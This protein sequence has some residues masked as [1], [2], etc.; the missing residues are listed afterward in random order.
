MVANTVFVESQQ[1]I[2]GRYRRPIIRALLF[3]RG[4]GQTRGKRICKHVGYITLGP[5][6]CHTIGETGGVVDDED[7]GFATEAKLFCALLEFFCA[8]GAEAICV[9]FFAMM[10]ASIPYSYLGIQDKGVPL[11][12][13]KILR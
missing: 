9:S 2:D 13:H 12:R 1:H 5:V 8:D 4:G 10:L 6:C 7:V 3:Q 11:L